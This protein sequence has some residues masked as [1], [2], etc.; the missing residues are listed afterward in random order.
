[1][2]N[3]IILPPNKQ[4][5]YQSDQIPEDKMDGISGIYGEEEMTGRKDCQD[6][7]AD[8]GLIIKWS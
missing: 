3:Y 8:Q 5:Y 6:L 4:G 1:M 2:R 7:G